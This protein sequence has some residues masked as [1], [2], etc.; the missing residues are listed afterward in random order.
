MSTFYEKFKT[1][2]IVHKGDALVS[3]PL[4]LI[5]SLNF[6]LSYIVKSSKIGKI[7][8][9]ASFFIVIIKNLYLYSYIYDLH[10]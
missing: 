3:D 2:C 5:I 1:P 9:N 4:A 10:I 7:I 8:M 6:S